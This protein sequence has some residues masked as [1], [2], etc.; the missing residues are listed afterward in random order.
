MFNDFLYDEVVNSFIVNYR[1]IDANNKFCRGNIIGLNVNA[2]GN[3]LSKK[4]YFSTSF[5][6]NKDQILKFLPTE[7]DL[8]DVYK[9]TDF[10]D[11]ALCRRGVTFAIKKTGKELVRQ[12]HFKVS[13]KHYQQPAFNKYK[14]VFLPKDIFD[15]SE[16]YGISYEYKDTSKDQKNYIYF[17]NNKAKEYFSNTLSTTINCDT[18]EFTQSAHSQKIIL[19]N[20]SQRGYER[21]FPKLSNNLVY[22][23]F[24]LY[25]KEEQYSGY[26][27]PKDYIQL[28]Q[29]GEIDT[30]SVLNEK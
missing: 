21:Y 4:F 27:Y 1:D 11:N 3:I 6:L 23:N 24:G 25:L 17:K 14:T 30:I 2:L 9:F 29:T 28:E 22:K 5:V 8:I 13:P 7:E 19:L 16:I 10:S 15:G 18:I 12:F 26:I 20:S